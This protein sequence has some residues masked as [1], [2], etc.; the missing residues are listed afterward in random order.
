MEFSL[1]LA[2]RSK[3]KISILEVYFYVLSL[4]RE[5][6][7]EKWIPEKLVWSELV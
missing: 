3:R 1:I 6:N 5:T 2:R 7:S 4:S